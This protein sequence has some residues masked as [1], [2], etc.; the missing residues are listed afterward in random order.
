M[1]IFLRTPA[2]KTLLDLEVWVKKEDNYSFVE[3]SAA[4][5]I[6]NYSEFL[7]NNLDKKEEI[8]EDF[9]EISELR[10][11]LWEVYFMEKNNTPS[12]LTN[13]IVELKKYLGSIAHYYG[14]RLI[15]D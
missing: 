15:T 10:G 12:E 8:V 13:V 3:L 14:L 11:W 5:N 1:T 4:I 6:K 9:Q 7:L 2:N